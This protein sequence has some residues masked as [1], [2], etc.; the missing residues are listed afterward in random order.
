MYKGNS[1]VVPRSL[2]KNM[3]ELIHLSHMGITKCML[4]A[5]QLLYW[6][7]MYKDIENK[8]ISCEICAKYSRNNFR[9][10]LIPHTV[11]DWPWQKIGCDLYELN[12]HKYLL[13]IDNFSKYV[14]VCKISNI[15]S[16]TVIKHLKN[17]FSRL[18]IPQTVVSGGHSFQ[19]INSK[20]FLKNGNFNTLRQ[21][22]IMLDLMVW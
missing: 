1:L 9:E 2:R 4:K 5:K 12:N 15:T 21:V 10:P 14:E 7:G 11:P 22:H 8:V 16:E 19:V 17:I 18:G 13:V 3:I 20:F 6:P